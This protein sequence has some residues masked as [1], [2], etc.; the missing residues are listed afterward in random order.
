MVFRVERETNLVECSVPS[1]VRL[2]VPVLLGYVTNRTTTQ[3]TEKEWVSD[4]GPF[5]SYDSNR[6]G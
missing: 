2:V 1:R 3:Y 5:H 4:S 6:I